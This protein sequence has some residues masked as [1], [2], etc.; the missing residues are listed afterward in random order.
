MANMDSVN[1]SIVKKSGVV[2]LNKLRNDY[3]NDRLNLEV[4]GKLNPG[5]GIVRLNDRFVRK[6]DLGFMK[7][8]SRSGRA[9]FYAPFKKLGNNEIDTFWF[10]LAVIWIESAI[11]YLA[12][13]FDL[14]RKFII[15]LGNIQFRRMDAPQ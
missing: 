15:W 2:G 11:L 1:I 6:I 9:H 7:G 3:E 8:T 10:N 13:C 14:F 4:L 12:L 5:K